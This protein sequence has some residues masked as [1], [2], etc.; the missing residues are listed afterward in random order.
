LG[1]AIA[2]VA[3]YA[4]GPS[5]GRKGTAR[6]VLIGAGTAALGVVILATS[7][8]AVIAA[9]G[10]VLA[11]GGISMCW[12]LLVAQA[13]TGRSRAGAVVGAV[14]AVGYLGMV[15]GP[16]VVGWVAEAVGLRAALG[17]LAAGA[18]VVAVVPTTSSSFAS[19]PP[20]PA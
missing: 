10:L 15:I 5:V 4:L 8:T 2:A 7:G 17:V 6:G 14:S 13:G 16:A 3:R 20:P 11:A 18:L 1:Y 19:N 9:G 12:P